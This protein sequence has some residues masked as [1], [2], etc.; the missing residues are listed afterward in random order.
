[1]LTHPTFVTAARKQP[2]TGFPSFIPPALRGNNL[3][4][5]P[6]CHPLRYQLP[7]VAAKSHLITLTKDIERIFRA[8][9]FCCAPA[10][11]ANQ[12]AG[13]IAIGRVELRRFFN[14]PIVGI[15]CLPRESA[16]NPS[17]SQVTPI[18]LSAHRLSESLRTTFC[19]PP[20]RRAS[21]TLPS[22]LAAR[23]ML[24]PI[25]SAPSTRRPPQVA[26]RLPNGPVCRAEP[27]PSNLFD[28]LAR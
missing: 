28:P 4:L 21:S 19:F 3:A 8:V 20:I 5:S 12:L 10:A 15:S 18:S 24:K 23:T 22:G 17:P 26:A 2:C 25:L 9:R 1:M 14:A 11:V 6:R 27:Q 13:C 16:A 7:R